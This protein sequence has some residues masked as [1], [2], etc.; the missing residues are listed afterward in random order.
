MNN[1][2]GTIKRLYAY[3]LDNELEGIDK[4]VSDKITSV[5]KQIS[6]I[7]GCTGSDI[8]D[9]ISELLLDVQVESSAVFYEAGF[10]KAMNIMLDLLA[11]GAVSNE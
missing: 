11:G 3:G 6:D 4:K 7:T 8:I 9:D 5:A 1:Y 10:R 2:I